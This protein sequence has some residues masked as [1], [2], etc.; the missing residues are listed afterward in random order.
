MSVPDLPAPEVESRGSTIRLLATTQA[1]FFVSLALCVVVNH[2][3]KAQQDGISFYGVWPRTVIVVVAGYAAAG[4]GLWRAGIW[5]RRAAAPPSVF[6][7][8]RVIAIGLPLLLV[9]PYDEG[10]VL[11]WSHMTIGVA[12][13]LVQAAGTIALVRRRP[14]ADVR[15]LSLVQLAGG[16]LAAASLPT[17]HFAFLLQGETV[18]EVAYGLSLLVWVREL[19]QVQ[20]RS[21][22]V[23]RSN[24]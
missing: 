6:L 8:V 24:A 22:S 9:T 15:I 14:R 21:T 23:T 13:A 4:L 20:P 10:V 11:N 16:L 1:I 18:Y 3:T 12:M 5:F 2:S 19:A 7:G 17:W